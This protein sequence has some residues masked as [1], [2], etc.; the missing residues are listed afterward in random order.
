MIKIIKKTGVSLLTLFVMMSCYMT[1]TLGKLYA[2]NCTDDVFPVVDEDGDIK[3]V[4]Y[5]SDLI[6]EQDEEGVVLDDPIIHEA[7]ATTDP[8]LAILP[9]GVVKYTEYDGT[10]KGR[11]GYTNGSSCNYAA[12][13]G[14]VDSN[15]NL[16]TTATTT[17]RVKQSGVFMDINTATYPVTLVNH[18]EV[19]SPDYY[20]VSSGY[21]MHRYYYT[22]GSDRTYTSM[23]VGKTPSFI[24]SSKTYYSNDGIYFYTDYSTMVNDY[25]KGCWVHTN[26]VNASNPYYNYYQYLSLRAPSVYSADELNKF[27]DGGVAKLT[28]ASKLYK[29]GEDVISIQNTYGINALIM[30]ADA[31]LE[32]GWG[33]S[34]YALERNNLFGIAAYDSNTDAA[35]TFSSVKDCL[36]CF[37]Y[38]YMSA[39]YLNEA[40]SKYRGPHEGNKCSGINV[41]YCSTPMKGEQVAAICYRID[42]YLGGY[43]V[44]HYAIAVSETEDVYYYANE[45]FTN[46][47]YIS[48]PDDSTNDITR[49]TPVTIINSVSGGY[50]VFSDTPLQSDRTKVDTDATYDY[51]RD[52]CYVKNTNLKGAATTVTLNTDACRHTNT[53][54]Q[55]A[56]NATHTTDGY[57]GDT[58]CVNCGEVVKTGSTIKATGHSI[59]SNR[60]TKAATCTSTGIRT[61]Y[62]SCGVAIKTEGIAALG[63]NYKAVSSTSA[64]ITKAATTTYRCSRCSASY[65]KSGSTVTSKTIYKGKTYSEGVKGTWTSS[66][67]KIATVNSSGK[68]TAKKAGTCTITAKVSGKTYKCKITVKNCSISVSKTSVTVKK[69]KSTTV[70][71]SATPSAGITWSSSNKKIA[72]V[73]GGKITGKKKG[74]CTITAK[75]NGVSKKIK[76]KV[77]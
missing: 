60:V 73:S 61:Y 31:A 44:N 32:S 45:D 59:S 48:G 5:N 46:R 75:A 71:A 17:V 7:S 30:I 18:T 6:I 20:Y 26:A 77:N 62:C 16:T 41:K 27:L 10:A 22:S 14:Y 28:S 19:D 8:D 56:V 39:Q 66:N 69:G 53:T 29:I 68:I 64:K 38:D 43:D 23:K 15:R 47:L 52:Y 40:D 74:S 33:C 9:A 58:V 57:T 42:D 51:S 24:N 67:K 63:H 1:P 25:R 3:Y 76:V 49:N 70:T 12:F 72:T 34:T 2:L 35:K 37:A 36:K 4:G 55:N 50:K 11:A 13:V 21:L 54:V 65:V